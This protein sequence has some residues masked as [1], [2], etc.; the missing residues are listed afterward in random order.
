MSKRACSGPFLP[1]LPD[2]ALSQILVHPRDASGNTAYAATW[3]GVFVTRDGGGHWSL[4]GAGLPNVW[5]RGLELNE[6][7]VLRVAIYG[8]GIWEIQPR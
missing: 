5:A 1:P 7:G 4:L 2:V 8:R 6:A 3:I